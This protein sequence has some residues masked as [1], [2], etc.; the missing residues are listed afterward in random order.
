MAERISLSDGTL[1]S[2]YCDHIQRYEFGAN[3]C[4]GKNVLDVGC[5]SGYGGYYLASLPGT[6]VLGVDISDEALGEAKQFFGGPAIEF[7]K[8]DVEK[9][10]EYPAICERAP[11]QAVVNFENIEHLYHPEQMVA[12][13]RKLLDRD[14]VFIT[15][16]PNGELS[17]RTEHGYY[18]CSKFH[19]K[20]FTES[21]IRSV[22]GQSFSRIE[23]FG[24][25]KT[26]SQVFRQKWDETIYQHL[27]ELYY[28][29][30]SRIARGLKRLL[31]KAPLPPPVFHPAGASYPWEYVIRPRLANPF[32]WLP[33]FLIAVCRL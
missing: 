33:T 26:P 28:S 31:R 16:T 8:A 5:G 18:R 2:N 29:P 10:T 19:V 30:F 32:P 15:S 9:L 27:C 22:L 11:F 24:Q 13:V 6:T 14:G 3:Y 1:Y 7:L 20:E 17:E 25:W 4:A 23:L 12:G 21:E